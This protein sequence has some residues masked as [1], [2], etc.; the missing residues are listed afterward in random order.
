MT[1]CSITGCERQQACKGMCKYHYERARIAANPESTRTYR[2]MYYQQNRERFLADGVRR[3]AANPEAKRQYD[4]AYY[5]ANKDSHIKAYRQSNADTIASRLTAWK[6]MHP[7]YNADRYAANKERI[8]AV[9]KAWAMANPE[10]DKTA[11]N[12]WRK[13][14]KAKCMLY[15]ANNKAKNK[16]KWIAYQHAYNQK[17]YEMNKE[18]IKANVSLWRKNN[19]GA[20]NEA[21]AKRRAG[22]SKATPSWAN[23]FFMREAYHL[24]KLRTKATGY[25]WHVDH[26]VPLQS[27][28]VCGL[29]V[30]NN[31]RVIPGLLNCKKNNRHWPDMP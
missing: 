19:P 3:R 8:K 17:Y 24:A 2:T 12:N 5:Q 20:H 28:L 22:Q 16:A 1:L 23:Q 25:L 11:K 9:N 4:R 13:N 6:D 21:N 29:H 26:I 27:L 18:T 14:N 15:V 31:L 7:T 30:E 10:K